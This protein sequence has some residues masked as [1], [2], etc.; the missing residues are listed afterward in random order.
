MT[1]NLY[2]QDLIMKQAGDIHPNPGPIPVIQKAKLKKKLRKKLHL[3]HIIIST[4]LIINIV[5]NWNEVNMDE[6]SGNTKELYMHTCKNRRSITNQLAYLTT[7][8][9][10]ETIHK[11]LQT[12]H[13]PFH[14][15][16]ITKWR[17]SY[18]PRSH[19]QKSMLQML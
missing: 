2:H 19:G 15:T 3:L 6:S 4:C 14:A 10:K 18:K 9:K 1:T 12:G 11:H 7:H 8:R 13:I 5:L 16:N 17:C